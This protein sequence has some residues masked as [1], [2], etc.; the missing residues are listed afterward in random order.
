MCWREHVFLHKVTPFAGRLSAA[1]I[2]V[3]RHNMIVALFDDLEDN[4]QRFLL[5]VE[6]LYSF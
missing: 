3:L 5:I 1:G 6:L 2:E 4:L